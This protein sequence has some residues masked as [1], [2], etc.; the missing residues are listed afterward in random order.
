MDANTQEVV[1]LASRLIER[2]SVTPEDAG[3]Q[4]LLAGHLSAQG[5]HLTELPSAAVKNLWAVHGDGPPMLVLAGHTDVVPAGPA[6]SWR[7][8]PFTPTV[9]DGC[10]YGRGSADMKGPLAAMITATRRFLAANPDHAGSLA[11]LI[12]SDEEGVA[13]DGTVTVVDWLQEQGIHPEYC[14]VGE[15]SSSQSLGDVIR[16]GR[17]GSLNGTLT[18]HG[19]QG[20][21]A[22][23]D[24]ANNPIH[25][26]LPVLLELTERVWDSGN[27]AFPPTSFQISNIRGG[28]GATNVIPGSLE[29][30]FNFRY[31]T[32]QTAAGLQA[33]V[34]R[35]LDRSSLDYDLDW[36]LSG[37]PFQTATQPFIEAVSASIQAVRPV[38][39]KATTG[40]GTSDGRFIARLCTQVI[41]LGPVNATIHS[42]DE[43]V[44]VDD[45]GALADMYLGI[46]SRLLGTPHG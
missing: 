21:V 37:A 39:P 43:H 16:V 4:A 42:V 35:L 46:L 32:E 27:A 9:V 29:I 28:T 23:P 26:A 33:A 17:R 31:C 6:G 8:D 11:Y 19:T 15:P 2:E 40:G 22:Y 38:T 5:F 34:H 30:Q 3:C 10:L 13:T 12:T 45:L 14:I 41:E 25:R 24:Q 20:H 1:E 44:R 18:V 36:A 7:Y